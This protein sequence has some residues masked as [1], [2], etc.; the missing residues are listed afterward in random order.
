M[1]PKKYIIPGNLSWRCFSAETTDSQKYLEKWLKLRK[2][3]HNWKNGSDCSYK[4]VHKKAGSN[5]EK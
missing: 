1:M 5:Q 3:G 4:G 2:M